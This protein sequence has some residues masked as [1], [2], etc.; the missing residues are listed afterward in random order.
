MSRGPEAK[1]TVGGAAA[2]RSVVTHKHADFIWC[3]MSSSWLPFIFDWE[4][5][6]AMH[7][8]DAFDSSTCIITSWT[9]FM[10]AKIDIDI[11]I[12][13]DRCYKTLRYKVF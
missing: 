4:Q 9:Q 11:D 12:D 5:K 13:I 2:H 1:A 3:R 8:L 7:H 10:R 6:I